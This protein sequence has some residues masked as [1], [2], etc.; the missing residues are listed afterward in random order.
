MLVVGIAS[1]LPSDDVTL[2]DVVLGTWIHDYTLEAFK[3]GHEVTYAYSPAGLWVSIHASQA[4][5]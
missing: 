4:R 1:G 2:G 5:R 3:T